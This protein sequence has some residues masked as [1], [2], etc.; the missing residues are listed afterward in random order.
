VAKLE[1]SAFTSDLRGYENLLVFPETLNLFILFPIVHAA[2]EKRMGNPF[3]R[4]KIRYIIQCTKVLDKD[5]LF[6]W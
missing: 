5:D 3:P 2:V 4:K 1:I 6:P